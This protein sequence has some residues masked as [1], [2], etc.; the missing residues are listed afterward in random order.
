MKATILNPTRLLSTSILLGGLSW[1]SIQ[2]QQ[3]GQPVRLLLEPSEPARQS[4]TAA[5]DSTD[6]NRL[7]LP[8]DLEAT[9]WAEAPMFYNPTNI[10]V[11]ARGRIWVTEAVNY[12]NFNNKPETRLDHPNGERVM[13]LEDTDGDG[14][15]D[16]SKVYV[17]DKDLVSPLGIAVIGNKTIVSAAPHLV[18]YTDENGDDKPDKKE[19][20]L[21]GFGGLDHD[22]S[23]HALVAGPDGKWY[24]NTG[25]AGPHTVT[26]KAGWTL[27]SGSL[28]TGGTPY[29]K[30]NKGNMVSDDGRVW[31]G[32]LA[33]RINPDGTGLKVLGHNFR[34]NYETAIDSY[35]NLWQ[36][37]NDDQVVACRTSWLMEGG[38][39]GYFS[40]DGT[41][42]WQGDQRPGQDIPTAHWHQEDPGVIPAGDISGAG[43]PTGMVFYEGDELGEKYRGLLLSA[44]AGRN[45]IFSYKP[46]PLGAGYRML[47]TDF[48]STFAKVDEDYKWN[49]IKEDVRK[50]FRP[51]DVAVGTDGALYIADWFDPVVG[52]HQMKDPKGYGRI[53]R[54]TPKGKNLKKPEI[55]TAK[56]K[57]Q[58]QAVMNPAI[59]VRML[60]FEKL[61]AQGDKVVKPVATLLNTPNPYHRARAVWLLAQLG[62]KGRRKVEELLKSDQADL[63]VTAFRALKQV[64]PDVIALARQMVDDPSPAVRREVAIALRDVPFEQCRDLLVKLANHYDG[65]DRFY[66]EAVGLAA[67][68]KEEELY[69]ALK[70]LIPS[71]PVQWDQKT[72]NLIWRLHPGSTAE[73]M[74]QRAMA[75][76]LTAEARKQAMVAL[77]FMKDPA[78]ARAMVELT[79]LDDKTVAEQAEYW[80]SFRRSND[81]AMLL[82]WDEVMPPKLSEAEQK[83]L[84]LRQK[85]M[86]EYT[87]AED[88]LKL[89]KELAISPEGGKLLVGLAAE[90]KL[91]DNL[92]P[93]ISEV[94]FTNPDQSVRTMAGD[95]FKRPNS[96]TALSLK[97][98]TVLTGNETA[99]LTVFKT[100]CATCHRHGEQGKDIGPELTKIHQKFDRNGLLDAILNPSAGLAFGYEPWLVTT[101]NGQTYYGFLISD[102]QQ[103]LVIKDAGGQKH[104]IPTAQVASRKQYSTSLMPDPASLGLS[105]QQLADLI[106]YLLKKS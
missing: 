57:G 51:S 70:P 91:A 92:K 69:A 54:I 9:L 89:A 38:N 52:G 82:N 56:T 83:A 17:E 28:Y 78:A 79:K 61:K 100:T 102:G 99:G 60:G 62:P 86:D 68:K 84:A 24:F 2:L 103:A 20:F 21:T 96:S 80:A 75:P 15:A 48:I 106:A 49:D 81:W 67:D 18:I 16:Q 93:A 58:I 4:I 22:H 74:K 55:N 63:R 14:K 10:D 45:V 95:Y 30:L 105:E 53:Y 29:N 76:S 19:I 50:W 43:S 87:P 25:N 31:V 65:L 33:L 39:M 7:Y 12:R 13:I 90:K 35:G 27:R 3:A 34:N 64:E 71:N 101:K 11:D 23:L 1:W 98:I 73:L 42:Y 8:D 59:N 85:L 94:I 41:R 97:N 66:L 6:S 46:E 47:R 104:T 88:K 5:T 40:Q 72:A 44:E 26:D 77:G 36:N 37:D 32:G